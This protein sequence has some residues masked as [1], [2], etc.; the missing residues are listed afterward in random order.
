MPR[1]PGASAQIEPAQLPTVWL[2]RDRPPQVVAEKLRSGRWERTSHGVYVAQRATEESPYERARRRALA[3][4]A[5]TDRRLIAPHWFSHESAALLWG[6]PTWTVPTR[7]HVLGPR[8]AGGERT[9]SIASHVGALADGDLTVVSGLPVTSLARTVA[10]CLATLPPLHG[11]VIADSALHRGLPV[12]DLTAAVHARTARNG[13]ARARA[14]LAIADDGAE[15]PGE[16]AARFV[17]VRDGMPLPTTQVS[18][19]TR[20]GTYWADLGWEEFRVL[21]EYDGRTKYGTSADLF[22]EKRRHDALVETGSRVLRV[23]SSD[24]SSLT[25]R[26]LPLLPASVSRSLRPR[27]ALA[28]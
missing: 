16:S 6:L 28:A 2:T 20:L 18:V 5:G 8:A 22:D 19:G 27:R 23:T 1:R 7:T 4:I 25:K 9:P 26:V 21:L 3:N 11:L 14:V 15:S 17:V 10:D 12:A 24:L 13:A